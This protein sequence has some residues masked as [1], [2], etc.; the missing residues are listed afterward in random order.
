MRRTH[1]TRRAGTAAAGRADA[2]QSARS[3][4][5]VAQRG[6]SNPRTNPQQPTSEPA[7]THEQFLHDMKQH[8]DNR[9]VGAVVGVAPLGA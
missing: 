6:P 5:R 1:K 2:R 9:H 7:A 3:P 4:R 8:P